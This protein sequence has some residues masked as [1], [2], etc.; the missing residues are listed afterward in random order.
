MLEIF[1]SRSSCYQLACID[2]TGAADNHTL[3]A[4]EVEIS[5]NLIVLQGIYHAG[6]IDAILNEVQQGTG[7]R[8]VFLSLEIHIGNIIWCHI[9]ALEAVHGCV[10]SHLLSVDIGYIVLE[11]NHGAIG[12]DDTVVDFLSCL[13]NIDKWIQCKG[14]CHGSVKY[15]SSHGSRVL[16]LIMDFVHALM[17]LLGAHVNYLLQYCWHKLYVI[18]KIL[19]VILLS[20]YELKWEILQKRAL[21]TGRA[22]I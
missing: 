1:L 14:S 9:K 8:A 3:R 22:L 6:Y 10:V 12:P 21:P 2:D 20:L 4:E 13:G 16:T 19:I 17:I 5:S 11:I 18:I 7:L 15:P